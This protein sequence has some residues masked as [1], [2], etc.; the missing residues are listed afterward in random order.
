MNDYK[1]GLSRR[2]HRTIDS[3]GKLSA[4]AALVVTASIA[5]IPKAEAARCS[6]DGSGNWNCSFQERNASFNANNGFGTCSGAATTRHVRW[7]VP[8]GLPPVGGWDTAFFY[9]GTVSASSSTVNPFVAKTTDSYGAIYMPQILH[10]LLDDP[11]G[12]GKKYAV[13]AA[14]APNNFG[15]EYWD[16]NGVK[17]Y[18][19][20]RDFCFLP[21]LF[22]EVAGGSYGAASQYNMNRRFAFGI[23]SGGY[24]TSRMAV[25]FNSQSAWKAL[26]VVS[27]SYATCSGPFCS[28]PALPAN[29][30]PTKFWHGTADAT[31][32]ISTMRLYYNKLAS[33]GIETQKVEHALG[34]QFTAD[35]LGPGGIKAWFDAHY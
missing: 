34:H 19:T 26:A 15:T 8:E 16:T 20:T 2:S 14:E 33:Q 13:I 21:D 23:S 32:P 6:A 10:E 31:V 12:T 28:V 35:D 9:N 22:S 1:S 24:N 25:T 27:A 11:H 7:Q 18:S 3:L 30:P 5:H 17:T 4:C 29:H